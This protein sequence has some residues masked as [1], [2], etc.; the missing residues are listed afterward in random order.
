MIF[1][2]LGKKGDFSVLS[3]S[4]GVLYYEALVLF[5]FS[6]KQAASSG[7]QHEGGQAVWPVPS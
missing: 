6:L 3:R 2:V 4:L 5:Q 7:R 1:L